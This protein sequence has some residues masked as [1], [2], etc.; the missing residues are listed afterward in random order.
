M[1]RQREWLA[2]VKVHRDGKIS[3][4]EAET[5]ARRQAEEELSRAVADRDQL[6]SLVEGPSNAWRRLRRASRPS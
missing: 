1:A 6:R 3:R 5:R 4:L 2:E